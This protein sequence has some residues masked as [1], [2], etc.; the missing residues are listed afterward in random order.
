MRHQ[1]GVPPAG[2]AKQGRAVTEGVSPYAGIEPGQWPQK[3]AELLR[4]HPAKSAELLEVVRQ[5]WDDLFCCGFGRKPYRIGEDIFPK[6]QII[7]FLLHELIALEFIARYPEQW[8]GEQSARDKD[9]VYIPD[10]FYSVEIKTSSHPR[11]IFGNRSY[12]QVS[13]TGRR[14]KKSKSGF[15]LTVNFQPFVRSATERPQITRVRFGWL[16]HSDWTG[17]AAATGQQASLSQA[18]DRGKLVELFSKR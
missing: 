12:A 18:A 17:Q 6:P 7:G 9:L 5:A 1:V 4:Q 15:Y 13:A 2:R 8:R 16:D 3:T 14:G 10:E 11:Q